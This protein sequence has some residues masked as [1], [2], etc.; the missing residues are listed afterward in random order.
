[1]VDRISSVVDFGIFIPEL[2]PER[3]SLTFFHGVR[4][5]G[6]QKG[7]VV[8]MRIQHY[9]IEIQRIILHP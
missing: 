7:K 9:N 5:D 1:M 3:Y 8:K 4:P 6:Q 2:S